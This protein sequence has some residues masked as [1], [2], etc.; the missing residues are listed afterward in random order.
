MLRVT[1]FTFLLLGVWLSSPTVAQ[2]FVSC[3]APSDDTHCI[4]TG[5]VFEVN[6]TQNHAGGFNILYMEDNSA[7]FVRDLSNWRVVIGS[8][9]IGNDVQIHLFGQD[10]ARGANGKDYDQANEKARYATS[11]V[12]GRSG[13]TG[14][15]G[16]SNPSLSLH[17]LQLRKIGDL[18]IKLY[19]GRGGDGGNGGRG[20]PGGDAT[21]INNG[22][23]GGPGGLPG[24][25]GNGGTFGAVNVTAGLVRS[26]SVERLIPP[27]IC[28]TAI[29][30]SDPMT[31]KPGLLIYPTVVFPIAVVPPE[32]K[33]GIWFSCVDKACGPGGGPYENFGRGG[34]GGIWSE[35]GG[36]RSGCWATVP[37]YSVGGGERG[38]DNSH[39]RGADGKASTGPSPVLQMF[40]VQ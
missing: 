37:P 19:P 30:L 2:K 26:A 32:R 11:G 31:G 10:G 15:T 24:T 33:H 6:A 5:D 16:T 9:Y 29:C 23:D 18:E 17:I 7:I 28:E 38:A 4:K 8:A 13:A 21:C 1:L 35:G 22:G 12:S 3:P 20:Q 27:K 25:G 14:D 39:I 40:E 36:G 34:T